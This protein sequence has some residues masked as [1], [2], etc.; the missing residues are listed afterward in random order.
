MSY[1]RKFLSLH[2]FSL[3]VRYLRP[4]ITAASP[5]FVPPILAAGFAIAKGKRPRT[6]AHQ[7]S[8]PAQSASAQLQPTRPASIPTTPAS[9][10]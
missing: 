5:A 9:T 3:S 4:P 2:T 10:S 8:T 7:M 6:S 1:P